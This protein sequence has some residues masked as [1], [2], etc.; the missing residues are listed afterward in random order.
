MIDSDRIIAEEYRWVF[1]NEPTFHLNGNVLKGK[2]GRT[3]DGDSIVISITVP[4]FYPIIKPEIKVVTKISHPNIDENMNLSLQMMDEWEPSYRLRDIIAN[5]RRLF[6]KSKRSIRSIKPSLP[7]RSIQ[8]EASSRLEDEILRLQKQITELN[9]QIT[10]VKTDKLKQAG[11][12]QSAAFKVS[13]FS[14]LTAQL[15][16]LEDLIELLE[17]KFED[18]DIDQTD[19][20]RLYRKYIKEKYVCTQKLSKIE[21]DKNDVSKKNA[22]RPIR[23]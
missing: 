7:K 23:H 12:Q 19:F 21:V 22:N 10:D 4:E 16:A 20:F 8:V 15:N 5:A 11:I 13:A 9:K 2:V 17:I 14:D 1:D 3:P 6:I 18:A